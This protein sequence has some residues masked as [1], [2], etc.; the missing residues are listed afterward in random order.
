MRA[1]GQVG[2]NQERRERGGVLQ[3]EGTVEGREA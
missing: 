2:L 3:A 1:E